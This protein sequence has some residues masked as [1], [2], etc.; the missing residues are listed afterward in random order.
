MELINKEVF[1]IKTAK[2]LYDNS[3]NKFCNDINR[4]EHKLNL[5]NTFITS[6]IDNI[7]EPINSQLND[8]KQEK[9]SLLR[10]VERI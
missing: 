4:L 5:S 9:L 8:I 2:N 7:R 3:I 1:P 6:E 10:E